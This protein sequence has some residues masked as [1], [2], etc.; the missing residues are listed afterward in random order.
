MLTFSTSALDGHSHAYNECRG[1][2]MGDVK[3]EIEFHGTNWVLSNAHHTDV[4]IEDLAAFTDHLCDM[5][6]IEA[7]NPEHTSTGA[8]IAQ[9]CRPLVVNK[10]LKKKKA[11]GF[12]KL[13]KPQNFRTQEPNRAFITYKVHKKMEKR[14]GC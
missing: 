5:D 1:A 12:F 4:G 7:T 9:S 3:E 10:L 11:K 6:R 8:E 13:R 14:F 2:F